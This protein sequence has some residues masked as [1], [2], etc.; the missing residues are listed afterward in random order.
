MKFFGVKNWFDIYMRYVCIFLL[1]FQNSL[2]H[3]SRV[4]VWFLIALLNPLLILIFWHGSMKSG[5]T[6]SGWSLSSISA[7]YILQ[8]FFRGLLWAHPDEDIAVYDIYQGGIINYLLKPHQYWISKLLDDIPWRI[9]QGFFG[10]MVFFI[11]NLIVKLK[12]DLVISPSS[13]FFVLAVCFGGYLISFLYGMILGMTAFWLTD[14]RGIQQLSDVIFIV[15]AGTIMPLDL[16]PEIFKSL[17]ALLPYA[18]IIYYPIQTIQGQLSSADFS[19]ILVMQLIWLLVLGIICRFLWQRGV[20]A[21]T[22]VS[23]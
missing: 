21:Y 9:M 23:I 22:G 6:I 15:F 7:Y 12:I 8:I 11:L 18:Y 14:F 17:A 2:Q 10:L 1:S 16:F 3:R 13:L 20:K 5:N 4:F 19:Q